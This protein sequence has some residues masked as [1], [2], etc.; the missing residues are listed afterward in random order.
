MKDT[1]VLADFSNTTSDPVFDDTLKHAL[2]ADLEQSPFLNIL[3]ERQVAKNLRFMG[4][5]PDVHI[6]QEIAEGVCQRA[7][8]KAVLSG[9]IANLGS[10]YVIGL[11]ATNCGTGEILAREEEQVAS[12]EEVLKGMARAAARLREK[13]GESLNSIHKYDVPLDQVTTSSLEAAEVLHHGSQD[14]GCERRLG[15][16]PFLQA[17]H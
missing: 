12:K 13:L 5:A 9:S 4:H 7:G 6:T 8:S 10:Q 14:S 3:S 1:V 17:R 11:S 15:R 16:H 2:A